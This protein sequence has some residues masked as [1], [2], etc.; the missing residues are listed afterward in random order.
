[1]G[2]ARYSRRAFLLPRG[3]G[4]A[5]DDVRAGERLKAV[6]AGHCLPRRGIACMSCRDNCPE[7]AIRFKPRAGG[8]FL[9]DVET[10]KCN[11]CGECMSGC[12]AEAIT[13]V[14]LTSEAA[15]G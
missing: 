12:P 10:D 8:P 7:D 9:P 4:I 11:G 14:A 1:M 5:V 3:T 6:I 15:D 2:V 13:L